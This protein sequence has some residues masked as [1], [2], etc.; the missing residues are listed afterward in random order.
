LSPSKKV[1]SKWSD[2]ALLAA[3]GSSVSAWF[4]ISRKAAF[5]VGTRTSTGGTYVLEIDWS[6]DGGATTLTTDTITTSPGVPIEIPTKARW[7]RSR[8]RN[9]HG[10][11]SFTAHNTVVAADAGAGRGG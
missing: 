5:L 2:T 1:A 4:D 8:V 10:S 9:T 11:L 6:R 3:G 7:F